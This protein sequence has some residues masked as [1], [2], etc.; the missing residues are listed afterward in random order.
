MSQR[1]QDTHIASGTDDQQVALSPDELES[2][3]RSRNK[4]NGDFTSSETATLGQSVGYSGPAPKLASK[5]FT[6]WPLAIWFI[7]SSEFCERYVHLALRLPK[8]VSWVPSPLI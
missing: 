7:M 5:S 1:Y 4:T 6:T 3:V 8:F 2:G